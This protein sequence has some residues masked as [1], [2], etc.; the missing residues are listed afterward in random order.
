MSKKNYVAPTADVL[1]IFGEFLL[2]SNE[3]PG[4]EFH[5]DI[6]TGTVDKL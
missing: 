4:D 3:L 5:P 6:N 1:S 2:G